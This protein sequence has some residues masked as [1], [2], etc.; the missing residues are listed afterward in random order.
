MWF[1]AVTGTTPHRWITSQRICLAQRLLE[2]TQLD[3]EQ[4]VQQSG[5]GTGATLRHHFSGHRG[6]SPQLYRRSFRR[7]EA[8]A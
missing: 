3:V 6:T 7:G 4:V 8:A 2:E 1:V 5:S